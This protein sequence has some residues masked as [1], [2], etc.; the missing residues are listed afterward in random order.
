MNLKVLR[1]S[2]QKSMKMWT[3]QILLGCLV[4]VQ[5]PVF[6]GREVGGGGGKI[7]DLYIA[8]GKRIIHYLTEFPEGQALVKKYGLDICRLQHTLNE[9]L[10]FV[11]KDQ[12]AFKDARGSD[13]DAFTYNWRTILYSPNWQSAFDN[14]EDYYYLVLKEML[15]SEKTNFDR[16]G[17]ISQNIIPFP[18]E[19]FIDREVPLSPYLQGA[20][21]ASC[22]NSEE[23]RKIS[24]IKNTHQLFF[25]D[26]TPECVSSEIKS[27]PNKTLAE[28]LIEAARTTKCVFQSSPCHVSDGTIN[29]ENGT[30][31]FKAIFWR[32]KPIQAYPFAHKSIKGVYTPFDIPTFEELLEE[33]RAELEY[34]NICNSTGRVW[35]PAIE[36]RGRMVNNLFGDIIPF[37]YLIREPTQ[38]FDAN[39]IRAN[40]VGILGDNSEIELI[41]RQL[42][43]GAAGAMFVKIR[44]I[45]NTIKDRDSSGNYI[46]KNGRIFRPENPQIMITPPAIPGQE[47]YVTI[48][49][50][51]FFKYMH[52]VAPVL[53]GR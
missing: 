39:I 41:D 15:R 35:K 11:Y 32:G 2:A 8:S 22:L 20:A 44:V 36:M 6:A 19:L 50:T 9:D 25:K 30:T 43:T 29:N 23:I 14:N 51:T 4:F 33:K 47:G 12:A 45:D 24:E 40:N 26:N 31:F 18:R 42:K 46:F 37:F 21:A 38:K 10:V 7:H 34:Y 53:I 13:V 1:E 5:V 49:S 28:Q 27:D 16:A 17:E 52:N 48:S 3:K